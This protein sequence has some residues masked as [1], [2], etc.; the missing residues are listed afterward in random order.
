MRA[1]NI[2]QRSRSKFLRK[3]PNRIE[4]LIWLANKVPSNLELPDLDAEIGEEAKA[5]LARG[6]YREYQ[7]KE[8][9][10]LVAIIKKL[11]K[12]LRDF[13]L[14]DPDFYSA[15]HY[16]YFS[17]A[18]SYR[19]FQRLRG[20]LLRVAEMGRFMRYSM[21]YN[22]ARVFPL[23][24]EGVS[25]ALKPDGKGLRALTDP[26]VEALTKSD[27]EVERIRVCAVCKCIFWAGRIDA[28]QC[29]VAK[30]K[31]VLSSRLNRNPELREQYN[32][33]RRKKRQKQREAQKHTQ[34]TTKK[35]K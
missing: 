31:S 26:L 22:L 21:F 27:V 33:A 7:E 9:E 23:K 6:E 20:N 18:D 2:S 12:N 8:H 30:C 10:T 14:E 34:S 28:R 4:W 1:E 19:F 15:V 35:G 25:V 5:L 13:I 24:L 32:K 3:A 29:G 17:L 11:P 16:E